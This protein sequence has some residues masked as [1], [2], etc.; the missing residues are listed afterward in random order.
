MAGHPHEPKLLN[1]VTLFASVGTL[2][3]CALPALLVLVGLGGAVA[4]LLSSAPWLVALSRNKVWVFLGAGVLL[5]TNFWYVYRVSPRLMVRGGSCAAANRE[6]CDAAHRTSR[7]MLWLAASIYP[8][9]FVV[10]F[11][12][13]PMLIWLDR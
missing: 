10:A 6:T 4:S 11:L 12:L 7:I 2:L 9:A 3:C 13:G 1:F 8:V 5:A